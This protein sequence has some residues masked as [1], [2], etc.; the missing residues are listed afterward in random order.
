M[1]TRVVAQFLQDTVEVRKCF[2]SDDRSDFEVGIVL[3]S[4]RFES[5]SKGALGRLGYRE[6]NRN[7][8]CHA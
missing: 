8:V 2:A 5:R 1:N 3:R 6:Q 4:E 7:A